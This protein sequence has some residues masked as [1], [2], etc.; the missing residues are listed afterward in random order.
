MKH[1]LASHLR[2]ARTCER[3]NLFSLT[4]LL[5]ATAFLLV[6]LGFSILPL[7]AQ[8]HRAG[9]SKSAPAAMSNNDVIGLASAGMGDDVIMA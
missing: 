8:A 4:A 1:L 2:F 3:P 5:F 9:T 7:R 6:S